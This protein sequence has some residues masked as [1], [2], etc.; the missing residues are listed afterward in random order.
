MYIGRIHS[1]DTDDLELSFVATMGDKILTD[2]FCS[3]NYSN[4]DLGAV[5]R[6]IVSTDCVPLRNDGIPS[7]WGENVYAAS[8]GRRPMD[9][10]Q[11][12]FKQLSVLFWIDADFT[13]W[14][15]HIANP[16]TIPEKGIAVEFEVE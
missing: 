15:A 6:D 7:S 10:F 8:K 3:K 11:E 14:V 9:I 13:D 2:R 5:L 12:F 16:Q 4:Q 1:I